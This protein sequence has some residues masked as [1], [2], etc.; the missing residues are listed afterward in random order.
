MEIFVL[1]IAYI[2]DRPPR[3]ILKARRVDW[4][5][6]ALHMKRCYVLLIKKEL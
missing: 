3:S 4:D 1:R 2:G 5:A 6:A